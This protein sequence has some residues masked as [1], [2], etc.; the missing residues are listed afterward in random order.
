MASLAH[1]RYIAQ[2]KRHESPPRQILAHKDTMPVSVQEMENSSLITLAAMDDHRA[3]CEILIRHIMNRDTVSY[4]SATKTFKEIKKFNHEGME[5][6]VLPFKMGLVAALVAG[7]SSIPLCFHLDTVIWF[8]EFFVTT[9][10]PPERDL[11][12]WLEVGTW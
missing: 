4:E 3:C 11:E 10:V 2:Q 12:T 7:F 5:L 6:T 8:N 9:D 1:R